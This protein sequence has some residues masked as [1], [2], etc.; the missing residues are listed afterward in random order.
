M[1]IYLRLSKFFVWNF[2]LNVKIC[3]FLVTINKKLQCCEYSQAG[4]YGLPP[5]SALQHFCLANI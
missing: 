3:I 2:F 4:T 5:R 1:I